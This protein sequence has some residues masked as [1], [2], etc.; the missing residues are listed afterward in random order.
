MKTLIP[1]GDIE[2]T[3]S[4]HGH[5][6][7]GLAI[8]IRAAELCLRELGHNSQ[9][10]LVAICETDMC[11]VDA[12]QMLTGCSVGKG[13]LIFLDYG[14]SSFTF[15]R[16][17]DAKGFRA[18]LDPDFLGDKGLRMT[19]LMKKKLSGTASAE[20]VT[21]C[22]SLRASCEQEYL[23][24][25]LDEL[26]SISEPQIHM[27]RPAKILNSVRCESCLEKLMESRSRYFDGQC[28][29]IPCFETVEQKI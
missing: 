7:P 21:E 27:P 16:R 19:Q 17:S 4:F 20:E 6:C 3:I 10:A 15:F 22:D 26:F 18:T 11:G 12:I 29:C 23:S 2:K 1:S 13:N 25:D 24:A 5:N 8:G 9:S 28:L 14:K